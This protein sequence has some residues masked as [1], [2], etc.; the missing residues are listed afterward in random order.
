MQACHARAATAATTRIEH[1]SRLPGDEIIEKTMERRFEDRLQPAEYKVAPRSR[2]NDKR[3]MVWQ[4]ILSK[5]VA[6]DACKRGEPP[7]RP[8]GERM[9]QREDVASERLILLLRRPWDL[10]ALKER[11]TSRAL[12]RGSLQV[13]TGIDQSAMHR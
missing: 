11:D 13:V 5:P 7:D 2:I 8:M 3:E 10:H 12:V 1:A 9:Q 4:Q 6:F